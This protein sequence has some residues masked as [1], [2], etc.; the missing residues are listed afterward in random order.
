MTWIINQTN[1][2]KARANIRSERRTVYIF[3]ENAHQVSHLLS[4]DKW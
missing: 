1:K 2:Y 3:L 4:M